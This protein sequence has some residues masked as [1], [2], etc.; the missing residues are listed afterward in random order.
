MKIKRR[1]WFSLKLIE[2]RRS[3]TL[4]DRCMIEQRLDRIQRISERNKR[5]RGAGLKK[6]FSC[7]W[8][9]MCFDDG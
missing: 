9:M 7:A 5:D 4:F 6:R 1:V 3:L 2:F 8:E